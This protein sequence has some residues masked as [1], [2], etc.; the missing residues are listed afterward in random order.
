MATASQVPALP[1]TT[2]NLESMVGEAAYITSS[3]STLAH[4]ISHTDYPK[5]FDKSARWLGA[6]IRETAAIK[7]VLQRTHKVKTLPLH[8]IFSSGIA[9]TEASEA[10]ADVD[11]A[12]YVTGMVVVHCD[13]EAVRAWTQQLHHHMHISWSMY[14]KSRCHSQV[15]CAT[16]KMPPPLPKCECFA[17][18]VPCVESVQK[19]GSWVGWGLT[20]VVAVAVA[21]NATTTSSEEAQSTRCNTLAFFARNNRYN[22]LVSA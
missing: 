16:A 1:T 22:D 14:V 6:R 19:K 12:Q 8:K 18:G 21:G 13:C 17:S 20:V 2:L 3:W 4:T 9:P 15:A 5:A 11:P 10:Q 7:V